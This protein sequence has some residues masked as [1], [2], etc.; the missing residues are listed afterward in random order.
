LAKKRWE[1]KQNKD[2]AKA[3]SLRKSLQDYGWD[4]KD[5]PSDYE[6]FPI[7]N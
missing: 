4:V 3:D 6:L 7:N 5:T 2:Y 1:A